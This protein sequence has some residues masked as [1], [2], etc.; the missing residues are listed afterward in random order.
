MVDT[1]SA[2]KLLL[3]LATHATLCDGAVGDGVELG[4]GLYLFS[5]VRKSTHCDKVMVLLTVLLRAFSQHP[6]YLYGLMA[7]LTLV[8]L[9]VRLHERVSYY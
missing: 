8:V 2:V 9:G 5:L 6:L 7:N 1:R 3:S 4:L